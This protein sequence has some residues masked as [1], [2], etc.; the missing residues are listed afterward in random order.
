MSRP[1]RLPL[2]AFLVACTAA[3]VFALCTDHVW[4]DFY[5]TYRSS[6]NLATGHGLV[7]NHGDRLHTFTSP[8]GVLLPALAS[9]LTFNSSDTGA[10]WL[11][12]AMCIAAFG[13]AAA[14]LVAA[15][16][17]RQWTAAAG[18]LL[19]AWLVTDAKSVDFT[20]NGMETGLLL[21]FLA[22][23][24]WALARTGRRRVLHLGAA[25]AGVMW[26]RPDG[27]IYIGLMAA[28]AW[29]F[30]DAKGTGETRL[31]L[32][33]VFAKAGALCA[34]LYL[35]WF[36]GAWWYYGTPVPHTITAKNAVS[37]A[38][39]LSGLL[40]AAV[41]LPVRLWQGDETALQ[42]LYLPSY[43]LIG[44]WPSLLLT[45]G[46]IV[47]LL[48]SLL[49][50]C[51]GVDRAT[52][53]ASFVCYGGAVY[54]TYFPYFPFPWYLPGVALFGAIALAGALSQ[55]S[56]WARL[57]TRARG[58][59]LGAAAV[60]L[61]GAAC[62]LFA[63]GRQLAAQQR[64]VETGVR[65]QLGEWLHAHATPGD[66]VFT[67]SLGY[68]GFF[69]ELKTYDF[70]GMSS[71]E[72]AAQIRR[73]GADW[74][75]IVSALVPTWVVLR[76]H[77]LKRI[78]TVT[79]EVGPLRYRRVATLDNRAAILAPAVP[80]RP[81][82]EHD[83]TFHLYQFIGRVEQEP[84]Q[85]RTIDLARLTPQHLELF[86]GFSPLP[87][88]SFSTFSY[89]TPDIAGR[90]FFS[91][92]PTS[93]QWFAP[94][95][96]RCTGRAEFLIHEAAYA[97]RPANEATNG[98]DFALHEIRRDGSRRTLFQRLLNPRDHPADRGL[99]KLELAID[100]APDSEL[101][102]ET[103]PGPDGNWAYDW[104]MLGSFSLQPTRPA[105]E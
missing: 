94:P 35:P 81:Y 103:T 40:K 70:P 7:F 52:R 96:P 84:L 87:L 45:L 99:Q 86:R 37:P 75:D 39:S 31:R 30:H 24:W 16:R 62:L 90:R 49:W 19:A 76:P 88:R 97:G 102:F 51:P 100:V 41:C 63:S 101:L 36:L 4:E 61:G 8:L 95:A 92:H 34:L 6:K 5:I 54:L 26:T 22:Y 13:G 1:S 42:A 29:V 104:A 69:S 50:L 27:C 67:A 28:A 65:R 98:V 20:I 89:S 44:G 85:E 9:L 48:A 68:I 91:I 38:H 33:A 77:E 18:A 11:F 43:F 73:Q 83:S 14:F 15:A 79:S 17:T 66:T 46:K 72:M 23:S 3:L 10:L 105:G 59:V 60:G 56:A 32:V 93:R 2:I 71:R 64:L 82:L 21:L 80:G 57:P 12:R 53:T 74:N 55:L 25:W 58:A 78:P 47:S